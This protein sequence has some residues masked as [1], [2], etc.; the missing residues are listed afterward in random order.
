MPGAGARSGRPQP[1]APRHAQKGMDDSLARESGSHA[2]V[3]PTRSPC[4][5]LLRDVS[6]LNRTFGSPG[7]DLML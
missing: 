7:Q 3:G 4:V 1:T 5:P 6:R 2:L